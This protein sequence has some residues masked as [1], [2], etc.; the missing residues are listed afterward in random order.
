MYKW[1]QSGEHYTL[2]QDYELM[3]E[4]L[5]HGPLFGIVDYDMCRDGHILLD[6]VLVRRR[7]T[8]D[9][10]ASVRGMTYFEAWPKAG[11]WEKFT[12][13]CVKYNLKFVLPNTAF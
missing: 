11:G 8:D 3:R 4:L 12:E 1:H 10:S 5:E 7:E 9:Y 6:P 13:Y 2:S